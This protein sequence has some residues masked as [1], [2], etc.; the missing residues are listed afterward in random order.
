MPQTKVETPR[1][2]ATN[3]YDL[4]SDVIKAIE[5]EPK[6]FDMG[7]WFVHISPSILKKN[8]QLLQRFPACGTVACLAGWIVVLHGGLS[9]T[10]GS[11]SKSAVDIIVNPDDIENCHERAWHMLHELRSMFFEHP[12]E[13]FEVGTL[14]YAQFMADKLRN[15]QQRYAAEL[16]ARILPQPEPK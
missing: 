2:H 15:Y 6:R 14:P 4:I 1:S 8:K 13:R 5:G 10:R 3:A 16:S 12:P 9:K 7:D 11:I